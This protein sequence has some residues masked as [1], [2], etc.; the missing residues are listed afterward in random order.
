MLSITGGGWV[1]TF[2]ITAD[3]CVIRLNTTGWWIIRD[4]TLLE[5]CL[6]SN[7]VLPWSI[8]LWYILRWPPVAWIRVPS[9]LISSYTPCGIFSTTLWGPS[10]RSCSLPPFIFFLLKFFFITSSPTWKQSALARFES[11]FCFFFFWASRMCCAFL[12]L[13]KWPDVALNCYNIWIIQH[14]ILVMQF[15]TWLLL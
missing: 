12:H 14:L 1:I 7:E 3:G 4:I 6:S 9:L 11:Y 8:L 15:I 10:N 13:P 5:A 2:N